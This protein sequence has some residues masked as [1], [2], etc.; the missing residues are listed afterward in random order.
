MEI[1]LYTS[2]HENEKRKH[3]TN[4]LVSVEVKDGIAI[5]EINNPPVHTLSEGVINQLVNVMQE[6]EALTEARVVLITSAGNDVFVAG[7][8]IKLFPSWTGKGKGFAED[9]SQWLQHPL[10]LIDHLSKPTIAVMDGLALGGGCELALACDLRIAEK[11]IEIGLPEIKLGL[12][13]G[14]GGTQRLPRLI[15]EGRAKEMMFTGK[16]INAEEALTIGL[17]NKVTAKGKALEEAYQLALEISSYSLPALSCM[18]KAVTQ[19]RDVSL[20]QGLKQEAECFGEVFQTK[21]VKEG[22]AAFIEKRNPKF[23][24]E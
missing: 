14:A 3:M 9:K 13:P 11:Q 10:D 5:V 16:S 4:Q 7:G 18:K 8:D 23:I 20:K 22:I 21:D 1:A 6:L 19:G 24:H 17:V 12:F 15:G 2:K